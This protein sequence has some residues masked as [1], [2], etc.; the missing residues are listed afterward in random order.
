VGIAKQPWNH[1]HNDIMGQFLEHQFLMLFDSHSKW[2]E[3]HIMSS[4]AA[5]PTI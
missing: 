1:L 3:A 5:A 2:M 4:I